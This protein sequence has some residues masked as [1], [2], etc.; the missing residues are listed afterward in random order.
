[1]NQIKSLAGQTLVYGMG[2]IVPRILNYL[3]LTPFYT[4]IFAEPEYG[5]F[6]KLYAY[7]AFFIVLLTFGTETSF[8]RYAKK[9]AQKTVFSNA[10]FFIIVTTLLSST[11]VFFNINEITQFLN[12]DGAKTIVL[13]VLGIVLTDI[14]TS[15]PFARL[16]FENK[17]RHFSILKVINVLL[18]IGFNVF[19]LYLLPKIQHIEF[20]Q[21]IYSPGFTYGYAFLSNL[22]ANAITLLILLPTYQFY[23]RA[24]DFKIIGIMLLYSYPIVLSGLAGM[25]NDVGDK[26]F[27]DF[28][29]QD[30]F[31]GN[32]AIG[33]YGANYKIATLM[34]IFIQMFKYAA[35]PFFFRISDQ[36]DHRQT[37]AQVTKAFV[38]TGL[39]IFIGIIGYIDLFKYFIDVEYRVG[40]NIVPFVLLGNFFFGVFYNVSIWYKITDKTRFGMY[41]TFIGAAITIVLNAILVPKY[42]Y[43]GAAIATL[44]CFVSMAVVNIIVGHKQYPIPYEWKK[45][46]T[47]FSFTTV[48][49]AFFWIFRSNNLF[50]SLLL[51]T[52]I[53]FTY[54]ILLFF[55]DRSLF[56]MLRKQD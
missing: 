55:T 14:L 44:A 50:Y 19:F 35:E 52:L 2:T 56:K 29:I 20:F 4:R 12:V 30:S 25:I 54:L 17:A 5:K 11:Y 39:L 27:L 13:I 38:Y 48:L 9:Y 49:A 37:Y 1:M 51:G 6:T 41:F 34:I 10:F 15:L 26:I 8:F 18:N 31:E 21:S 47:I 53:I 3:L 43:M 7:S 24:I 36:S 42:G 23:F 32:Y 45:M 22:L 33:V 16:R 40:L 46:G 28:F